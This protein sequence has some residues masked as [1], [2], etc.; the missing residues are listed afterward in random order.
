[1]TGFEPATTGS[2]IRGS[3]QLSYI[4]REVGMLRRGRGSVNGPT[5]ELDVARDLQIV[6]RMAGSNNE[7]GSMRKVFL[8]AFATVAVLMVMR[9]RRCRSRAAAP[10]II[11]ASFF[12]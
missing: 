4:H 2:T 5:S 12:A 6:W 8:V 11:L 9:F 10:A 3:N 1:M 7:E